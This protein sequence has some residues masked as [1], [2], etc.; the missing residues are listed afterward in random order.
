MRPAL[1]VIDVQN[2]YLSANRLEPPRE[3][4]CG[5]IARL[6]STFREAQ[7]PIFHVWTTIRPEGRQMP[8]WR[9][10][11]VSRCVAG[12]VGHAT[13]DRLRP[14][15]SEQIVEKQYY[16]AFE[17]NSLE[18]RLRSTG[19]DTVVLTGVYLRA[20]VRTTAIDAY[21]RGFK[22]WIGEEAVGDDDPVHG[23]ITRMYLAARLAKFANVDEIR[24]CV[25]GRAAVS[26][27]VSSENLETLPVVLS[28]DEA[29]AGPENSLVEH[30]SPSR[31][32]Q[33]LWRA[34]VGD[35]GNVAAAAQSAE[36]ALRGWQATD[37]ATRFDL[38]GAIADAVARRSPEFAL[39]IAVETGKPIRDAKLEVEFA[40]NLVRS[41]AR[42][43]ETVG[44]Q[45]QGTGW[46]SRRCPL[47]V[48]ALI[49]PWNNP[50]AIPLG[51][52]I[53][54]LRHGNTVVWKPAIPGAGIALSVFRLLRDCGL[55][56]GVVNI[57]MG[58]HTTAEYLMEARAVAGVSLT[59]SSAAG[60]AAQV[61]C[62]RN[63]VPL[64]AELGGNNAVIVWS[65]ADIG[66]AARQIA[67]G[68]FGSAGQR[69]TASRRVVVEQSV[70]AE[71]VEAL[72]SEMR[73]LAWGDPLDETTVVGP[74]VTGSA[75]RRI[76][77]TVER[78]RNEG[79]EVYSEH[80]PASG[81]GIDRRTGF[82]HPPTLICGA[83]ANSEIVQEETFGPVVVAQS[84]ENWRHAIEL[85]NGVRQ[86]LAAALFSRSSETQRQFLADA[87]AGI[88]RI[89]MSTAGAAGD[90]PFGG[91]KESGIGPPEHGA[92][93]VEFYTRY[94]TVYQNE[95]TCSEN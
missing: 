79:A 16:S 74:V 66:A 84:A 91:W 10:S 39:R 94:Q 63:R 93:D 11:G 61:V 53:P 43:G 7:L 17:D 2:D 31:I 15:A 92:A 75:L 89:N 28:D 20:C 25:A 23:A 13:P 41:C 35:P 26:L 9:S 3:A 38:F 81:D 86:G 83:A 71:F 90:A 14:L 73:G 12:S 1:V 48:V 58:D 56:P 36:R 34:P 69:C 82:Y 88:L 4:L 45:L 37:A 52:I 24:R 62:A 29:A 5:A 80:S 51:K 44:E 72:R 77:A 68:G 27:P 22:V 70:R 40:L 50:L 87:R 19:V 76:S 78:A 6:L 59:G 54:A 47:G 67:L 55:P 33:P 30:F 21:Q 65:D 60:Y 95:P 46:R 85:C 49:T 32:D 57:V 8:H 18:S 64:Q 42:L